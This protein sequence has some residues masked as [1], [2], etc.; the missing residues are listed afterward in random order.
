MFSS[1]VFLSTDM[2]FAKV[3]FC[4]FNV[5]DY[6]HKM[7]EILFLIFVFVFLLQND[8]N[9]SFT[10]AIIVNKQGQTCNMFPV[11]AVCNM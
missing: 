6:G 2:Q 3:T 4:M 1:H 9:R 8:I 10:I 5:T 11:Y 7:E